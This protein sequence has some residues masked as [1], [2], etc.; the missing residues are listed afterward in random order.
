MDIFVSR[1]NV[2]QQRSSA[3]SAICGIL[4]I[5]HQGFYDKVLEVPITKIFFLLRFAF[6]DN[7]PIILETSSKALATLF[8]N[9]SDEVRT[10]LHCHFSTYHP[11]NFLVSG[12]SYWTVPMNVRQISVNRLSALPASRETTV[13]WAINLR[14]WTWPRSKHF[15]T[16]SMAMMTTHQHWMIFI[17]LKSIWLNV[18]CARIFCREFS[19]NDRCFDHW[20]LGFKQISPS[21]DTFCLSFAAITAP[22]STA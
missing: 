15:T 3:I 12:R 17:W 4:N 18:C 5:Y 13:T 1:S 11:N 19:K 7:T 9:D 10:T 2:M 22:S 8:Y 20:V 16:Y 14:V 21:A 6:D